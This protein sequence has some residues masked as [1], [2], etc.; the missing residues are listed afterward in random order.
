MNILPVISRFGQLAKLS[1]SLIAY[2]EAIKPTAR[3]K[4]IASGRR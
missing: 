1:Q 3:G 4:P 2:A